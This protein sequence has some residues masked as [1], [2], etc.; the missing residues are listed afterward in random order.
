[1]PSGAPVLILDLDGTVLDANSFPRWVLHMARG[2]FQHAGTARRAAISVSV[3]AALLQRKLRLLNH[4]AFK[5]RMQKVWQ[6]ATFDDVEHLAEHRLVEE[7]RVLVRPQ[8]HALLNDVARGRVDA[9]LAT[10]AAGDYAIGLGQSL[11]FTNILATP[12][13]RDLDRPD[14][15]GPHKRDAVLDF[16]TRRGWHNRPLILY[17]DHTDDLPLM[18]IS[19][20]TYWFGPES[21]RREIV[22]LRPDMDLRPGLERIDEFARSA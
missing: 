1:M 20:V 21:M 19:N 18:R 7:L 14:N 6:K 11:G 22:R 16:L 13:T 5:H 15:V 10:A 17:T 8:F 3:M 9:V 12:V 4:A 2:R